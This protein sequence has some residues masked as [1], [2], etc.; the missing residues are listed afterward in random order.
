[1]L[2]TSNKLNLFG[3]LVRQIVV[4][5]P[6]LI[7][8]VLVERTFPQFLKALLAVTEINDLFLNVLRWPHL[9]PLVFQRTSPAKQTDLSIFERRPRFI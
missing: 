5:A 4:F 9:L 6:E 8:V 1:M 7:K 2:P 3:G